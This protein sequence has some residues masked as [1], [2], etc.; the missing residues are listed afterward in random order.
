MSRL[1]VGCRKMSTV[2]GQRPLVLTDDA[3]S[4]HE[5][6]SYSVCYMPY[7]IRCIVVLSSLFYVPY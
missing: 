3:N 4:E 2:T 6:S 7:R 5:G 1:D